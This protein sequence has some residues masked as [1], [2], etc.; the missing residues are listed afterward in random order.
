[1]T[2]ELDI[3]FFQVGCTFTVRWH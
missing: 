2:I 1:M 3:T